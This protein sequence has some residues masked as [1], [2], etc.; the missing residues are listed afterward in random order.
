MTFFDVEQ[1]SEEWDELRLGKFTASSFGDLFMDPKTAGYKK[2]ISKVVGERI[3][4]VSEE[5]YSSKMM[6]RGHEME[7]LARENYEQLTFETVQNGG[8]FQYNDFVGASPD[9]LVGTDGIVE[10][11]QRSYQIYFEFIETGKLPMVNFWQVHGQ[12]FVTGREWCD[13]A[14]FN[15]PNLKRNIIRVYRDESIMKQLEEKLNESIEIVQ[16]L[17]KK[18]T[19]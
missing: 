17:I 11:K 7:P 4:G 16:N 19:L 15:H 5:G 18:Y 13:Y 9:G 12:I 10:F 3:T 8:F 1:N 6:N 2:A 14:P